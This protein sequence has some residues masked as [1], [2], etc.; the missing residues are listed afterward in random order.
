MAEYMVTS[1]SLAI[2]SILSI[3]SVGCIVLYLA[4]RKHVWGLAELL[5]LSTLAGSSI[6]VV[7]ST[8]V[9]ILL[10][11]GMK[12][13]FRLFFIL[14]LAV[15]PYSLLILVRV[16]RVKNLKSEASLGKSEVFSLLLSVPILLTY[17]YLS[18]EAK[19][20]MDDSAEAY[21]PI[22]RYF[23]EYDCIP[24][25]TQ[26]YFLTGDVITL[27][28]GGSILFAYM[29]TILNSLNPSNLAYME[30]YFLLAFAALA[31][32][33]S[34]RCGL[35]SKE[36]SLAMLLTTSLPYWGFYFA[37]LPHYIDLQATFMASSCIYLLFLLL[38]EGFNSANV[39]LLWLALSS[40]V[41]TKLNCLLIPILIL[42]IILRLSSLWRR[43]RFWL[44]LSLGIGYP[45]AT[46]L[47]A[48]KMYTLTRIIGGVGAIAF[49]TLASTVPFIGILKIKFSERELQ[50]KTV[51]LLLAVVLTSLFWYYRTWITTGSILHFCIKS[52]DAAWAANF[53]ERSWRIFT[54]SYYVRGRIQHFFRHSFHFL[55]HLSILVLLGFKR[56]SKSNAMF[57]G[58]VKLWLLTGLTLFIGVQTAEDMRYILYFILPAIIMVARGVFGLFGKTECGDSLRDL[59]V[60]SLVFLTAFSPTLEIIRLACLSMLTYA[61]NSITSVMLATFT[62]LWFLAYFLTK[63]A[64]LVEILKSCLVKVKTAKKTLLALIIIIALLAASGYAVGL[65]PREH[66]VNSFVSNA[67]VELYDRISEQA[68]ESG[69]LI[70]FRAMGIYYQTGVRT[71][72]IVYAEEL[73][74]LRPF[75]DADDIGEGLEFLI[76]NLGLKL[77]VLPTELNGFD[78]SWYHLLLEEVPEL[79]ILHNP[80]LLSRISYEEWKDVKWWAWYVFN[81]ADGGW[82]PYGVLDVVVRGDSADDEASL[83]LPCDYGEKNMPFTDPGEEEVTLLLFLYFPKWLRGKAKLDVKADITWFDVYIEEELWREEGVKL[84]TTRDVSLS[85]VVKV[86]VG[87]LRVKKDVKYVAARINQIEVLVKG[88]GFE[89]VDRL[90]PTNETGCWVSCAPG[91]RWLHR[92]FNLIEAYVH[93]T[94]A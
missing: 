57:P 93:L 91:E 27:P 58:G 61:I 10:P 85:K 82:R 63:Q 54:A 35:T 53:L 34:R 60:I 33:F 7:L 3:F 15:L 38:D 5:A 83:F 9:G 66:I 55:I 64:T 71:L 2:A 31:Y 51:L 65:L 25:R 62:L 4:M 92:G 56:L 46:F 12:F 17:F 45:V 43:C 13:F 18:A 77:V 23:Y 40:A 29:F 22:A 84:H 70:T 30:V 6:L 78:Y 41:T 37:R 52:D 26:V 49:L 36:S 24:P 42:I 90:V 68:K 21:L 75:I 89:I 69:L 88:E 39:A 11:H 76:H 81:V 8:L 73:A 86:E 1:I 50:L 32:S 16:I 44:S 87:R 20:P 74:I 47:I 79:R 72:N 19:A 59:A 94:E 80:N 48:L 14:G 67:Y 28:P